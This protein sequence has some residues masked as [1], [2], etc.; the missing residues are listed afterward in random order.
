MRVLFDTNVLVAAFAARG[1]CH[2]L[3]EHCLFLH[4]VVLSEQILRETERALAS[5]IGLPSPMVRQIVQILRRSCILMDAP[6]LPKP[7]CRDP[8][9]DGILSAAAMGGV[10]CLVTGDPDLLV[11]KG[12]RGIPILRPGD[13]WRF[14]AGIVR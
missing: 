9:D 7:V 8:D 4:E 12:F 3:L 14:E 6:S 1:A 13:F 2:E 10:A 5:K 11:L